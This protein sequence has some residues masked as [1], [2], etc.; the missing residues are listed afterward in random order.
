MLWA[1]PSPGLKIDK[2]FGHERGSQMVQLA[3]VGLDI[4][5]NVF[6]AYGVDARGEKVLSRKLRRVQIKTF[7]KARVVL[8]RHRMLSN[9]ALLGPRD[10]KARP[11]SPSHVADLGETLRKDPEER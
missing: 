5:K 1:D 9:G 6:H 3:T 7:R 2:V 11:P 10:R 4:A 8:G